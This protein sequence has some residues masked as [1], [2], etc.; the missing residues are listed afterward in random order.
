MNW[1]KQAACSDLPADEA[2]RLFFG[3]GSVPTET[4]VLCVRCPVK[5]ECLAAAD[6]YETRSLDASTFAVG[7]WGGLTAEGRRQRRRALREEHRLEGLNA[8]ARSVF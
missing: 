3:R 4:L 5:D 8:I 7:I 2:E 1:R 6:F